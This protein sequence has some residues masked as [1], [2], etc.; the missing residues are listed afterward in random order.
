L[1]TLVGVQTGSKHIDTPSQHKGK[2][3]KSEM[4][5]KLRSG[6]Q[7]E[8]RNASTRKRRTIQSKTRCLIE[9]NNLSTA[10]EILFH[11]LEKAV[12]LARNFNAIT[13]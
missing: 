7:R 2:R 12:F 10:K 9:E 5:F 8:R 13:P 11:R 6:L 4:L 1:P 3:G